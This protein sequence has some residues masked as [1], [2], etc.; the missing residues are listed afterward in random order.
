MAT[1]YF[2]LS[3]AV[4]TKAAEGLGWRMQLLLFAIAALLVISR[5]PDVVTHPQFFAEDGTVWFAEAYRLTFL[6]SLLTPDAGYMQTFPRLVAALATAVPLLFAPALMNVIGIV[7]QV[8][9]VNVLA[10][11]RSAVW[12]SLPLRLLMGFTY[13]ALPNSR[14]LDVVITNAQWHL[15]LLACLLVLAA[16][17]ST[18]KKRLF[19][20]TVLLVSG[21]TGPFCIFLVPVAA[22][23]WWVRRDKWGAVPVALTA[24]C[25]VIQIAVVYQADPVIRSRA[26]LGASLRAVVEILSSHVFLAALLGYAN[27]PAHLSL[28]ALTV[29]AIAGLA[30]IVYATLKAKWEYK[31]MIVF[32]MLVFA[33]SLAS[34][35]VSKTEPQWLILKQAYGIRYWFFPML[36][37]AWSLLWCVQ[38]GGS[39][40]MRG[41]AGFL[42]ILMVAGMA[43]DWEYPAFPDHN[44]SQSAKKFERLRPGEAMTFPLYPDGWSMQLVKDARNCSALP[45]GSI[46]APPNEAH[47]SGA[48]KLSGWVNADEPVKDLSVYLDGTKVKTLIPTIARP[49]VDQHYPG[50]PLKNKGWTGIIDVS[51]VKPGAHVIDL[52]AHLGSGCETVVAARSIE[53]AAN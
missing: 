29:V 48:F 16:P 38:Y 20:G 39:K 52:R 19:D 35:L 3:P 9:P 42:L 21:L 1:D 47:V 34:P 43:K 45:N 25:A 23:I 51:R 7:V 32:C 36:A 37:F 49:D 10:A 27:Y 4:Q 11:E 33:A 41:S 6:H 18:W 50:S 2:Q 46:D 40:V 53:V 13:I 15:A 31:L 24:V 5:R 17:P 22:V 8:L 12:G 30:I 26:P 44:F 28:L 14:E